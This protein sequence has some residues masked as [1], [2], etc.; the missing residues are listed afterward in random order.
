MGRRKVKAEPVVASATGGDAQEPETRDVKPEHVE[1]KVTDGDVKITDAAN[2]DDKG[3]SPAP[4]AKLENTEIKEDESVAPEPNFE[5]KS[6]DGE[7]KVGDDDDDAPLP[8]SDMARA[9]LAAHPVSKSEPEELEHEK[10]YSFEHAK[11]GRS[12]C[13]GK[14]QAMIPKGAPRFGSTDTSRGYPMTMW[15][16]IGCV[17][18]RQLENVRNVYGSESYSVIRGW[19]DVLSDNERDRVTIAFDM[20]KAA[21]A[22]ENLLKEQRK[23]DKE[24]KKVAADERRVRRER[25]ESDPGVWFDWRHLLASGELEADPAAFIKLVCSWVGVTATGTKAAMLQ[26]LE[27]FKDGGGPDVQDD[28]ASEDATGDAKPVAPP[29]AKRAARKQ[30]KRVKAEK[31][32]KT[33]EEKV[34]DVRT[35]DFTANKKRAGRKRGKRVKG[36][37]PVKTNERKSDDVGAGDDPVEA[38]SAAKKVGKRAKAEKV[39]KTDGERFNDIGLEDA[40]S[41]AKPA[42]RKIGKRAKAEK[43]AKS[44]GDTKMEEPEKDPIPPSRRRGR[45]RS[46][47]AEVAAG[48]PTAKKTRGPRAASPE[49]EAAPRRSR[50]E[51]AARRSR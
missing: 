17:T 20:A 16:C 39:T 43:Q 11:S 32:T 13:K 48:A 5:Q 21:G 9:L 26:R 18:G 10:Y 30:G 24:A 12:V 31:P 41:Y 6:L 7:E 36:K 19:N 37:M 49:I 23:A 34:D 45:K 35:R 2:G 25:F 4:Y 40:T 51:R 28:V 29:R 44:D 1:V 42:A 14:C 47:G 22:R 33:G 3:V 46:A 27:E 8:L 15:R 50:A 38:E